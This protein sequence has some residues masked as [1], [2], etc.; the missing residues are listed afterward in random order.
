MNKI[1]RYLRNIVLF[2]APAQR[3]AI[4][5]VL[6][7]SYSFYYV[8]TRFSKLM[9]IARADGYLFEP[10]GVVS[11]LS[12]PLSPLL[13]TFIVITTLILN[14]MFIIGWR[15]RLSGP[16]FSILLFFVLS[17]RNSWSMIYH[18][19]NIVVL[20]VIIL[21][22][23]RA[24]DVL[25]LDSLKISGWTK[26]KLQST[27]FTN[28]IIGWQYG[29]PIMLICTVT[30]ISYFLSGVAKIEGPYGWSWAKGESIRSQIA[31]DGIRK[32]LLG[33]SASSLIFLLYNHIYLFY[34]LS[35]GTLI[36]ELG[37]P[38]AL[39]NRKIGRFWA[40]SAFIMHWGIYFIMGITFRF[41]LSGIAFLPFFDIEKVKKC[42]VSKIVYLKAIC[43]SNSAK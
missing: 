41:H 9:N 3:L 5:R 26:N 36:I 8:G 35:I 40:I 42:I 20:E 25:S 31:V 4:L 15:Y 24:A 39:I 38:L 27:S 10:V 12:Q 43:S 34:L 6:V 29:W 21:G 11:I 17:Y 19:Q 30:V 22:F 23:S 1:L 2:E 32:E 13:F 18:S 33:S 16:I 7:G 14:L 37:A 28:N